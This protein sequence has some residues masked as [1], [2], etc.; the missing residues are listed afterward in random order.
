VIRAKV[1]VP[2]AVLTMTFAAQ[3]AAQSMASVT[4]L[5]VSPFGEVLRP[6]KVTGFVADHGRGRD[7]SSQFMGARAIGIPYGAYLAQV[8]AQERVIA[9]RVRVGRENTLLVLSGSGVIIERGPGRPGVSGKVIGAEGINPVWLRLVRAFS[10]DL[11]CTIF[12]LSP[13]G[14]FAL[15]GADPAEY[16]LLVLS[17]SRVLFEGR[18]KIE[19]PESVITVNLLKGQATVEPR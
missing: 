11:C 1:A 8:V 5:A 10:E 4:I 19:N 7:Y 6:V 17:D 18:V 13:D 2:F 3:G 12:P 14:T 15:G 9:A 16:I